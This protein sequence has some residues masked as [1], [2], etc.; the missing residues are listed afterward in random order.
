MLL[1]DRVL[2]L[3]DGQISL[4][5]TV[6]IDGPRRRDNPGMIELR[7]RLLSELGVREADEGVG[8]EVAPIAQ[9]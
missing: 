1:A 3:T 7:S 5:V 8:I 4:D 6:E 9:V 2:V